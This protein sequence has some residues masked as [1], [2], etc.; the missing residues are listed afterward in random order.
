MG[1]HS[2]GFIGKH[3]T[4]SGYRNATSSS[5][6]GVSDCTEALKRDP[7]CIINDHMH[8]VTLLQ[9]LWLVRGLPHA[10]T[11]NTAGMRRRT[12]PRRSCVEVNA[13]MTTRKP[14]SARGRCSGL[15]DIPCSCLYFRRASNADLVMM[16]MHACISQPQ[17]SGGAAQGP[18]PWCRR[19]GRP[20]D[21]SSDDD[22]AL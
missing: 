14:L 5:G 9:V 22:D 19:A 6:T 11:V 7:K 8:H 15:I 13:W 17:P 16:M 4:S 20:T 10:R 18:R 1:V 2:N 21:R 3:V 12:T